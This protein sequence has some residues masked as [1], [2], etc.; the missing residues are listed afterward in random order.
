MNGNLFMFTNQRSEIMIKVLKKR[1]KIN[2]EVCKSKLTFEPEDVE[3]K[4]KIIRCT[5]GKLEQHTYYITCPICKAKFEI[6]ETL[7]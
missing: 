3:D 6:G 7:F 5:D 2:C 1:N 4:L